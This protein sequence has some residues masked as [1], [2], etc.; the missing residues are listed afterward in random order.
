MN[1]LTSEAI[2][3]EIKNL[4]E[5][6]ERLRLLY[7]KIDGQVDAA[8]QPDWT[9]KLPNTISKAH[10]YCALHVGKNGVGWGTYA[11]ECHNP[12]YTFDSV[13]M[14]R[15]VASRV[16][17]MTEM[18]NFAKIHNKGWVP[19]WADQ[20]EIKW[21]LCLHYTKGD[22]AS[23]YINSTSSTNPCLFQVVVKGRDIA[24]AMLK[25]FQTKIIACFNPAASKALY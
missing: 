8:I 3:A 23:L 17:L 18:I 4:Q 1:N 9:T 20:Q 2:S 24:D 7:R 13:D 25:Y 19:N 21:G 10:N 11:G 5:S 22:A 12:L 6:I 15:L 14:A 16:G